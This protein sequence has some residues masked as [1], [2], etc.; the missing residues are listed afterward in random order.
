[1]FEVKPW[2]IALSALF[3]VVIFV[4]KTVL[5]FPYD[6][7]LFAPQPLLLALGSLLMGIPGATFVS[8][9][10]GSLTMLLRSSEAFTIFLFSIIY[11]VLID[12]FFLV[13]K[14]KTSKE[15]KLYRLLV[16][17]AFSSVIVGVISYYV[18]I[19][20]NV[21]PF[22]TII[23][24]ATMFS[25]LVNGVIAGYLTEYIWRKKLAFFVGS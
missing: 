8:L 6:K 25:G 18:A 4:F 23:M 7:F 22:H 13:F 14:V 9:V 1:M 15:V 5:P 2:E 16:S 17:L 10:S 19:M 12:G 20:L 24:L 3:G 21:M 11:G